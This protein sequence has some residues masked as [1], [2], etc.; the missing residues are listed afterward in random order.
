MCDSFSL[1]LPTITFNKIEIKRENTIKFL[2]III[3]KNLTR[4]HYIEAV[5]NK[6]SK[7]IGVL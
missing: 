1:Q 2:G 6:I 4:K 7:E 5:E 3:D